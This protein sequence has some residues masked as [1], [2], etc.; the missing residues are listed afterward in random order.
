MYNRIRKILQKLRGKL[1]L[2]EVNV[3]ASI[4]K[5]VL[6]YMKLSLT[7]AFRRD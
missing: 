6:I 7:F 1:K 2:I 3:N 5:K 4:T